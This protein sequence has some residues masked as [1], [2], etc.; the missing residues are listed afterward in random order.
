MRKKAKSGRKN[1]SVTWRRVAGPDLSC[2]SARDRCSTSDLV[3]ALSERSSWTCCLVRLQTWMPS[4]NNSPRI[5]SAPQ[6]RLSLAICLRKRDGVRG[7]LGLVILNLRLALPIQTKELPMP[8]E[9]GVWLH[10]QESLLP[11][12]NQP[13]QQDQEDAIGVRACWPF[14]LT[15]ENGQLVSQKGIFCHQFRLA[16]ATICQGLQRQGGNEWFRPTSKTSGLYTNPPVFASRE[17]GSFS[18]WRCLFLNGCPK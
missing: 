7:D 9:Q 17:R 18:V 1:R 3:E 10:D 5:L 14:Y 4:F 16:S 2:V 11:R 8:S 13:G 15:L 12:A 6:S